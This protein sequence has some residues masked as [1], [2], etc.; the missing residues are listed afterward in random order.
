[1]RLSACVVFHT[2]L[3]HVLLVNLTNHFEFLS[4][5]TNIGES[6][7]GAAIRS[8][9]E[10]TCIPSPQEDWDRFYVYENS[11]VI[12]HWYTTIMD[13]SLLPCF[14]HLATM[15]LQQVGGWF[16][17]NA[18]YSVM[19][20]SELLCPDPGNILHNSDMEFLIPMARAAAKKRWK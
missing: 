14:G 15:E 2:D 10:A 12:V 1:M 9:Y 17:P 20:S 8:F 19:D 5:R 3:T 18:I 7:V 13:F 11:D 4:A 16:V 6:S